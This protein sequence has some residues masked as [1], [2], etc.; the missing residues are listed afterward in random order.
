MSDQNLF[1]IEKKKRSKSVHEK[2]EKKEAA[3]Q[4]KFDMK[5]PEVPSRLST[6]K[7]LKE[8]KPV[9]VKRKA[10][11]ELQEALSSVT[12]VVKDVE[13]PGKTTK[14]LTK[15]EQARLT[16]K[17]TMKDYHDQLESTEALLFQGSRNAPKNT[18]FASLWSISK[19]KRV[20]EA[21]GREAEA[22]SI[23]RCIKTN[24]PEKI[25]YAEV[26][27]R[28]M[29]KERI[30][31]FMG[32]SDEGYRMDT[33][34]NFAM[35]LEY[36]YA[37]TREAVRVKKYIT[38][39]VDGGY[40]P[41]S[42]DLKAV[43]KKIA[44]FEELK[45]YLDARVNVVTS[46][47]YIYFAKEDVNYTDKQLEDFIKRYDS[48]DDRKDPDFKQRNEKLRKYLESVQTLRS[49]KLKRKEG[50]SSVEEKTKA[51]AKHE[52]TLLKERT[53]KRQI[54][55]RLAE[56]SLNY[57]GCKRYQDKNYDKCYSAK[58]FEGL[59]K[60]F[61]TVKISELHL[62]SMKDLADYCE[63]NS[64]LFEQAREM[65]HMLFLAVGKGDT[66]NISDDRFIRL[67]AKLRAFDALEKL[68]MSIQNQLL[69]NREKAL[70]QKTFDEI[71]RDASK[72]RYLQDDSADIPGYPKLGSNLEKFY[73]AIL[74][75]YKEEHKN[76][77]STIKT[78]YGLMKAAPE[79]A[80]E[81]GIRY[82]P[83][84]IPAWELE[85]RSRDFQRNAVVI[86][87]ARRVETYAQ[88]VGMYSFDNFACAYQLKYKVDPK[89][90]FQP[91][92]SMSRYLI[93]KT[94][95]E[96]TRIT[97]LLTEGK[98]EEKKAFWDQFL[99]ECMECDLK[100]I[101][102]YDTGEAFDNYAYKNR[103]TGV[104]MNLAQFSE[105]DGPKYFD[106]M[107]KKQLAGMQVAGNT[108]VD[109]N[110]LGQKGK[111]YKWMHGVTVE[112]LMKENNG[113]LS[114]YI[115]I[116]NTW[117]SE[118]SGHK[119]LKA[120]GREYLN[121]KNYYAVSEVLTIPNAMHL[122]RERTIGS[123]NFHENAEAGKF[124]HL[125]E[126]GGWAETDQAGLVKLLAAL[127]A[128]EEVK[129][130]ESTDK[131]AAALV[132]QTDLKEFS[133]QSY[134]EL[135]EKKGKKKSALMRL[136]PAARA[137]K[138]LLLNLDNNKA[139][140]DILGE[141]GMKELKIRCKTLSAAGTMLGPGLKRM[142]EIYADEG[143]RFHELSSLDEMLHLP[144][145]YLKDLKNKGTPEQQAEANEVLQF[146][147]DLNGFD[148]YTPLSVTEARFRKELN[149][150][151]Q[152]LTP[153]SILGLLS[154]EK[155]V[156]EGVR[157]GDL[158]FQ[159]GSLTELIGQL[160]AGFKEKKLTVRQREALLKEEGS[161]QN[162]KADIAQRIDQAGI[163]YRGKLFKIKSGVSNTI[164]AKIGDQAAED[165]AALMIDRVEDHEE[166]FF[167]L[168]ADK[169][170]RDEA[171]DSCTKT[172]L[173]LRFAVP[174]LPAPDAD[175]MADRASR[176]EDL[177]HKAKAYLNL[178]NANPEYR[179]RL[180]RRSPKQEKT[181]YERIME[182]IDRMLAYSDYYRA[183]RLL[184][185]DT[186]YILHGNDELGVTDTGALN[187]E[188]KRV[189][190]LMKLVEHHA[191]KLRTGM[192]EGRRN[193]TTTEKELAAHEREHY[194]QAHLSG[195]PDLTKA[196]VKDVMATLNKAEHFLAEANPHQSASPEA[197]IFGYDPEV[198]PQAEKYRTPEVE[199]YLEGYKTFAALESATLSKDKKYYFATERQK[200]LLEKL[201]EAVTITVRTTD[202]N[203]KVTEEKDQFQTISLG[204][205]DYEKTGE[206]LGVSTDW[207]RFIPDL[208]MTLSDHI[209]DE[210]IL[211]MVDALTYYS[212][213]EAKIADPETAQYARNRWLRAAEKI[214]RLQYDELKRYER[215]YGTLGS[216]M[217]TACFC[218]SLGDG[219]GKLM[220]RT[221]IAQSLGQFCNESKCSYKGRQATLTEVLRDEGLITPEEYQDC[222]TKHPNYYQSL[223]G[224]NRGYAQHPE[225]MFSTFGL[226]PEAAANAYGVLEESLIN[227]AYMGENAGIEG[228][229][230]T[231][232]EKRKL[233]K[234]AIATQK[235][236]IHEGDLAVSFYE[237]H[238]DLLSKEEKRAL[239]ERR[240]ADWDITKATRDF[241]KNRYEKIAEEVLQELEKR[242]AK[243]LSKEE[244]AAAQKLVAFH[245]KLIR[246]LS[247]GENDDLNK[248]YQN[249]LAFLGRRKDAKDPTEE[250]RN[251]FE[252]FRKQAADLV[253][254]DLLMILT[255]E[256]MMSRDNVRN[257]REPVMN[258]TLMKVEAC[259]FMY[260]SLQGLAAEEGADK[261]FTDEMKEKLKED[262][263][264][265][266][267]PEGVWLTMA[268]YY[269]YRD[270]GDIG[271]HYDTDIGRYFHQI[272][273][274]SQIK[275]RDSQ[276][277]LDNTVLSDPKLMDF[278]E[279]YGVHIE[280]FKDK[281][282]ADD[283]EKSGENST[284]S[285]V[286]RKEIEN[287]SD[288]NTIIEE[289]EEEEIDTT[290]GREMKK[291]QEQPS[292]ASSVSAEADFPEVLEIPKPPMTLEQK[293]QYYS[294]EAMVE[295]ARA[296]EALIEEKKWTFTVPENRDELVAA[297]SPFYGKNIRLVKADGTRMTDQTWQDGTDQRLIEHFDWMM[298]YFKFNDPSMEEK[299]QL[300][301][302]PKVNYKVDLKLEGIANKYELQGKNNC[303]CCT[304]NA[305]LAHMLAKKKNTGKYEIENTQYDM[306]RYE[307][308][309]RKYEPRF[310][311]EAGVDIRQYRDRAL[312][313][314]SFCGEGKQEAGNIFEDADYLIEALE[315]EGY[316]DVCVNSLRYSIPY[317][318]L[319]ETEEGKTKAAN[320]I[321]IFKKTI[322]ENLENKNA[323]GVY[324]AIKYENKEKGI[325]IDNY[326]Y[327]TVTGIDGDKITY[328][329]SAY[330][331][332]EKEETLEDFFDHTTS[333]EL[334]W[335]SEEPDHAKLTKEY[336]N[337][338]YSEKDGY[339]IK[340]LDKETVRYV[341][342]TK[343][344]TVR[345]SFEEME[346]GWE[347]VTR[348][349]YIPTKHDNIPAQTAEEFF[350][351]ANPL[352]D[353]LKEEQ[354]AEIVRN[355]QAQVQQTQAWQEQKAKLQEKP[356][357]EEGKAGEAKTEEAKAEE[358]KTEE[359]KVEEAK[360]EETKVEEAKT[361]ETKTEEAKSEETKAE[362]GQ[363]EETKTEETKT[364]SEPSFLVRTTRAKK[365]ASPFRHSD[366]YK[367]SKLVTDLKGLAVIQENERVSEKDLDEVWGDDKITEELEQQ[368][369]ELS[370]K[371]DTV[372]NPDPEKEELKSH[373]LAELQALIDSR[374]GRNSLIIKHISKHHVETLKNNTQDPALRP[375]MRESLIVKFNH[376]N[377]EEYYSFG[378]LISGRGLA[379]A[380]QSE[381]LVRLSQLDLKQF[382]VKD[383]ADF[384]SGFAEKMEILKRLD[385]YETVYRYYETVCKEKEE[386]DGEWTTTARAKLDI[387]Q[388]IKAFYEERMQQIAHPYKPGAK[389][390]EL[391]AEDLEAR[392]QARLKA[393]QDQ[394]AEKYIPKVKELLKDVDIDQ[395]PKDVEEQ[396]IESEK[397]KNLKKYPK[398][399]IAFLTQHKNIIF[400][401][402]ESRGEK[403]YNRYDT[404]YVEI[405]SKG[406]FRGQKIDKKL[407][408]R[409]KKEISSYV[410]ERRTY[411]ASVESQIALSK[412][413]HGCGA[414]TRNPVFTNSPEGILI[415]SLEG[416]AG[417]RDTIIALSNRCYILGTEPLYTLI[418]A[419][420]KFNE[421]Y[422]DRLRDDEKREA[423]I[424]R[425]RV[426]SET[427]YYKEHALLPG[428]K[429]ERREFQK[430]YICGREYT[431]YRYSADL[432]KDEET[433]LLK[434]KDLDIEMKEA[435]DNALHRVLKE[436]EESK[437]EIGIAQM[438]LAAEGADAEIILDVC[439]KQHAKQIRDSVRKLQ[440][441]LKKYGVDITKPI[442]K[443]HMRE[444]RMIREAAEYDEKYKKDHKAIRDDLGAKLGKKD[445]SRYRSQTR[446]YVQTVSGMYQM[447]AVTKAEAEKMYKNLLLEEDKCSIEELNQQAGW[448]DR[449]FLTILDFDFREYN[450]SN[451]LEAGK[452]KMY[453]GRT[454]CDM[455]MDFNEEQFK[456]Y[457][458]LIDNPQVR[459]S[460]TKEQLKEV[461]ARW[462]VC[463]SLTAFMNP[464]AGIITSANALNQDLKRVMA[465]SLKELHNLGTQT[466]DAKQRQFYFSVLNVKQA[467]QEQNY[468][469]GDD[470]PAYLE[471]VRKNEYGL[472][473]GDGDAKAAVAAL[474]AGIAKFSLN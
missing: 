186:Y 8:K 364:V 134:S 48:Y 404:Y 31:Y 447:K 378:S 294:P 52:V 302:L 25:E 39:A 323:V 246:E 144:T 179:K 405:L 45:K 426:N 38:D 275:T 357:A 190:D 156:L 310:L 441:I 327:V 100:E 304:G 117:F 111:N 395:D 343:G 178:L 204:G 56:Y 121:R 290:H 219:Q 14:P 237:K 189:Y 283:T 277:N 352:A 124:R 460:L 32:L 63:T 234:D 254:Y 438:L 409:L 442:A 272:Q 187:K 6:P 120:N 207:P 466:K 329:D 229:H 252:F 223:Q 434:L 206:S 77:N 26:F 12:R 125:K 50:L 71:F 76:R 300:K 243:D 119:T 346:E 453:R 311:T 131:E 203:G 435:D 333:V 385:A 109:A 68:T 11:K 37:L 215:T 175:A 432:E 312:D 147:Q 104:F 349:I 255:P 358:V 381:G 412:L 469:E 317:G 456:H 428:E 73:Q 417:Y 444:E 226:P 241:L 128:L 41:E 232:G 181:D 261:W 227:E 406:T 239:K 301:L 238:L 183:F 210:E 167:L 383:D 250:K 308:K 192:Y 307:P 202:K 360:I 152:S 291:E 443:E 316:T 170:T 43:Q 470:I 371:D 137:A 351:E 86:D 340:K 408:T 173:S 338:T 471:R 7:A 91:E 407:L 188:E 382:A 158:L 309:L 355:R 218:H 298:E 21:R 467:M 400:D 439:E 154:G 57:K 359:A 415:G 288:G 235:A 49:L 270:A 293:K 195:R 16:T 74:K 418:Q 72:T 344:V 130:K 334:N 62:K 305:L 176:F 79:M 127:D 258:S 142:I 370:V 457:E 279:R 75:T 391:K 437:K 193:D 472:P 450:I 168:Y 108:Y 448:F 461:R 13:K 29:L 411:L 341:G 145:A 96:L 22:E 269:Y 389:T 459:C 59:L 410:K 55:N 256:H 23:E 397:K 65:E 280:P 88:T 149:A 196:K 421:N 276:C 162:V 9:E 89:S 403:D 99:Q 110:T 185:S 267:R 321:E 67:R 388:E 339:G 368:L 78:M 393:L 376:R 384:V 427:A 115:W 161:E 209:S 424:E 281:K 44:A 268:A 101:P 70:T 166:D 133:F 220:L 462:S 473:D 348:S 295:H 164:R 331:K 303:F 172:I 51:R 446:Y 326:H 361:E 19:K 212:R 28:K 213:P 253:K 345:K 451:I 354:E 61:E 259:H 240:K 17:T 105:K 180:Q 94:G 245:P 440:T 84:E 102:E 263:F 455:M 458:K 138:K 18:K 398:D 273:I 420:F 97:K 33:D 5:L 221:R 319:A 356:E 197:V 208:A 379:S 58:K 200:Q 474:K 191:G 390:K 325:S 163:A 69:Y 396:F 292:A 123:N 126:A 430:I 332:K 278:L 201:M 372:K 135:A 165:L 296:L 297:R 46:P 98:E 113:L 257:A 139:L 83:S 342:H 320:Q 284:D 313:L 299:K 416:A 315:K 169:E 392:Y 377:G 423:A 93:G 337:L 174:A 399:D 249:T 363:T 436:V 394:D 380:L 445:K 4:N 271:E 198:T 118:D 419:G 24:N 150:T 103:M 429:K 114:E 231:Y 15:E 387:L 148:L 353:Q 151:E 184:A 328:Y 116:T 369:A 80:E 365:K 285:T 402:Y 374:K 81:G 10:G 47:F 136:A 336:K 85:K 244:K 373:M 129:D 248:F 242:G 324:R 287:F 92:R 314:Y 53:E 177:S 2:R 60:E 132:M 422:Q 27:D 107:Q 36:N 225:L 182:R 106:E 171:L 468:N 1:D 465:L 42:I 160:S 228:P 222:V 224:K 335:L 265:S 347:D 82:E 199:N 414:D 454:L 282:K 34:E 260:S 64:R 211:D 30:D 318:V 251:A 35:T 425:M 214:F 262:R 264:R 247:D 112:D 40:L 230:L 20:D 367:A 330:P 95:E 155:S 159:P 122:N 146:I 431:Y 322:A 205:G 413:E 216:D 306:R 350:A 266:L 286:L 452:K 140:T 236:Q 54:I 153:E 217:P 194:R 449:V 289:E 274:L 233:W 90:V 366:K 66:K 401:L 375:F 157:E 464:V 386:A 141:R 87:Y 362:E 463:M 143:S 433:I 3:L